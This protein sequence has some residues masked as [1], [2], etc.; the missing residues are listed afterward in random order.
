MPNGKR[1]ALEE[2]GSI[3]EVTAKFV[4]QDLFPLKRIRLSSGY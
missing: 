1:G 4:Y 3:R 2:I